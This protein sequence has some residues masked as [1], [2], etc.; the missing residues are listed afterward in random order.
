MAV[1]P[2]VQASTQ[3][4]GGEDQLSPTTL[5]LNALRKAGVPITNEN[6]RRFVS[7]NARESGQSGPDLIAGLRSGPV[8]DSGPSVGQ[9]GSVAKAVEGGTKKE[10]Y[11][12]DGTFT[13]ANRGG[14]QSGS[15]PSST[16]T[17]STRPEGTPSNVA[18]PSGGPPIVVDPGSGTP[19]V[20]GP[21]SGD[22]PNWLD[23]LLPAGVAALIQGAQAI[24]GRGDGFVGNSPIPPTGRVMDVPGT[25][26]GS[27]MPTL[28][29]TGQRPQIAGPQAVPPPPSPMEMSMQNAMR[30][31]LGAPGPNPA[32]IIGAGQQLPAG[33]N[34]LSVPTQPTGPSTQ[35]VPQNVQGAPRVPLRPG[36]GGAGP[37]PG[38]GVNMGQRILRGLRLP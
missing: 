25:Q 20:L 13:D 15:K 22:G 9:S 37:I 33:I 18:T 8:E 26:I 27:D 6:I 1:A 19:G 23:A 21:S 30:P 10:G 12:D 4:D 11:L 5:V 32:D 7:S 34:P 3:T 17:Q 28:Q 24:P 36:A 29:I 35:I 16:T 31:A 2:S 14:D 38:A